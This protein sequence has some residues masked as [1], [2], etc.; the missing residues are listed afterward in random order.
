MR[1]A[2][3]GPFPTLL[4]IHGG[5]FTQY[6]YRLF[7]EFQIQVGAGFGVITKGVGFLPILVLLP[8]LALRQQGWSPRPAIDSAPLMTRFMMTCRS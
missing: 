6:G 4:N 3:N 7:D 2:G 5:P 1:P 8:Y